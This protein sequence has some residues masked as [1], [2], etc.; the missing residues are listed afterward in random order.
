MLWERGWSGTAGCLIIAS[1]IALGLFFIIEDKA[2]AFVTIGVLF[3]VGILVTR[4]FVLEDEQ[5]KATYELIKR[6][7]KK[8]SV[9]QNCIQYYI[10]DVKVLN[11]KRQGKKALLMSLLSNDAYQEG[12]FRPLKT[13]Q[14][15]HGPYDLNRINHRDFSQVQIEE[16]LGHFAL[17]RRNSINDPQFDK[18]QF[19]EFC[20]IINWLY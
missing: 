15:I 14:G 7:D 13:R 6:E 12:F 17:D 19:E 20:H 1:W 2:L 10:F 4:F 5:V 11:Q 3:V 16:V 8:I 9:H 18:D